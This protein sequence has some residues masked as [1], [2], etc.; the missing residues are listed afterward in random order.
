MHITLSFVGVILVVWEFV[1][2][3]QQ[4]YMLFHRINGWVSLAIIS[5]A[6]TFGAIVSRKAFGG[7]L[8]D[9]S[10]FY[11]LS[12]L[13]GLYALEGIRT[14]RDI[15]RHRRWMLRF[16]AMLGVVVTERL[17]IL[18]AKPIITDVGSY[19]ALWRCDELLYV[20][21]Q[22]HLG[23]YPLCLSAQETGGNLGHVRVAVH[24]STREAPIN[25]ASARRIN[26][27][28]AVWLALIIHTL[29]AEIYIRVTEAAN[30]H[31]IGYILGRSG[32]VPEV[33]LKSPNP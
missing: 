33:N 31:R 11:V 16:G 18:C 25:N 13:T 3:I 5:L 14:V 28:T 27:G 8:A 12:I 9:Q 10:G 22:S 30:R 26:S 4:H 32:T 1:P 23:A 2:A 17:I 6:T 19:Y 29:G 20:V 24:A 21:G 15:R 7:D